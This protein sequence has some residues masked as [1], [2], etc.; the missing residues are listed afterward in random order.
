VSGLGAA[1]PINFV[2]TSLGNAAGYTWGQCTYGAAALTGW[3]PKGLGNAIDWLG[4]APSH[5]LATSSSPAVG[6]VAVFGTPYGPD[7]HVAVVKQVNADG[8]FVVQEMNYLGVNKWDLR[9]VPAA[10]NGLLGFVLP[11][12][13]AIGG[14]AGGTSALIGGAAGGTSSGSDPFGVGAAAANLLS[15]LGRAMWLGMALSLVVLGLFLLIAEDLGRELEQH[16]Q[17]AEAA[18][19]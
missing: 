5:G 12:A 18:L 6:A 16:P 4:N 2:L 15:F 17:V 8:S 7:G 19:A 1:T 10:A 14:A 9:T 3:I 13:G 11:P